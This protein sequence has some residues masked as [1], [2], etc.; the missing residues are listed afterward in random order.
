MH[1]ARFQ[2]RQLGGRFG[3]AEEEL[4]G[5][6]LTEVVVRVRRELDVLIGHVRNELVRAGSDDRILHRFGGVPIGHRNL[7]QDVLGLNPEQRVGTG[8]ADQPRD[9][10]ILEGDPERAVIDPL[11]SL[12][13]LRLLVI[14][15]GAA[16]DL[17]KL[18][19][20]AGARFGS[21]GRPV[22]EDDVVDRQRFAIVP[23]DAIPDREGEDRGI[24][25]DLERFGD[26]TDPVQV[27]VELDQAVEDHVGD[28]CLATGADLEDIEVR[29]EL[30]FASKLDRRA[31][32][33]RGRRSRDA[34]HCGD[35]GCGDAG[36]GGSLHQLA[37]IDLL[38]LEIV[39]QS[40]DRVID[41]RSI[42][43]SY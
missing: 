37:A 18:A 30:G 5:L 28:L 17:A 35:G 42:L 7:A 19:G 11:Q 20:R 31:R 32:L 21:Q 34:R 36:S 27:V 43:L 10:R 22:G 23:G 24:V 26:I 39:D 38:R 14:E 25:R 6:H 13:L 29:R 9:V 1:L 2:L 3:Q 4:F 33:G 12:D 16:L 8:R 40:G 41:H 15:G